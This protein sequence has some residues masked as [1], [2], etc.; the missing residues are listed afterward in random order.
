V[1]SI[2]AAPER[3]VST[4]SDISPHEAQQALARST[5]FG[6]V[7]QSLTLAN[8]AQIELAL[9]I[10]GRCRTE[11]RR[12]RL[13]EVLVEQGVIELRTI[14][15]VLLEQKR[16]REK[17]G[18]DTPV[19]GRVGP[20]DFISVLGRGGMG[21]VYKAR[22][23][24]RNRLVA[25]KI[26]GQRW[27]NDAEFIARF[28]REAKAVSTLMHPN[29]VQSFG[30]GRLAWRP[31][32]MMEYVEGESLG[33]ILRS[34]RRLPEH[35]AL[36]IARAVAGALGH[37]HDQGIIHRD[38]KP[39][40]VLIAQ[41]GAV[42]LTDFGLAKLLLDADELTRTGVAV[43]TPHYIAPE[44]VSASRKAD[45]RADLY[46]L[47]AMLYHML[48]GEVPFDAP[49]NNDILLMHVDDPPPDPRMKAP[50]ITP[51]TAVIVARLLAKQ[52]GDRYVNAA[53]LI[54]DLDRVLAD[55]RPPASS[56]VA[57]PVKRSWIARAIDFFKSR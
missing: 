14:Q 12:I 39:D 48:A 56:T 9:Q 2:G 20:F 33:H 1:S 29:I 11:R 49:N 38:V 13:G 46:G 21:T 50:A 26:L 45:H 36:T 47:G 16:R 51:G 3:N 4:T 18:D 8:A 35:R 42:K 10:Q 52:P 43:G 5:L 24:K 17:S 30:S 41:D 27:L 44:Q 37:A 55:L 53:E 25:L 15:K 7:A 23:L 32:L 28:E 31:Y 54:R 19:T 40:N 22:D 34:E 6:D 57:T